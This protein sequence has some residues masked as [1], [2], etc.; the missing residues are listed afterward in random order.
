VLPPVFV[1]FREEFG[2]NP[3]RLLKS[4]NF[5][6]YLFRL[7]P[8]FPIG[9]QTGKKMDGKISKFLFLIVGTPPRKVKTRLLPR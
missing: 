6:K 9:F 8:P 2:A 4:V 1:S 7:P 3:N 5:S